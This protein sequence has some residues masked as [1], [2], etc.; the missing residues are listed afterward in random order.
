[1]YPFL[2]MQLWEPLV[3]V[4]LALSLL[5]NKAIISDEQLFCFFQSLTNFTSAWLSFSSVSFLT[6]AGVWAISVCTI[7]IYVTIMASIAA[8]VD[9]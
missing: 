1:M 7:R 2:Q 5:D 9:I 4:Q 3:F 8:F 6:G